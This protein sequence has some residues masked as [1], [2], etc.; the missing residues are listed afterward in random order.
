MMEYHGSSFKIKFKGSDFDSILEFCWFL[1]LSELE[2]SKNNL[3][4]H[5]VDY[6]QGL[7]WYPDLRFVLFKP[8]YTQIFAEVKPLSKSRFAT[9]LNLDKYKYSDGIALVLGESNID[10]LLLMNQPEIINILDLNILNNSDLWDVC[11]QTAKEFAHNFGSTKKTHFIQEDPKISEGK[12]KGYTYREVKEKDPIY[13][14]WYE[15]NIIEN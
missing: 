5:P 11:Y 1:F 4:S 7:S 8:T 6:K 9:E 12:Y 10:Y 3:S 14:K 2:I 13:F 15:E